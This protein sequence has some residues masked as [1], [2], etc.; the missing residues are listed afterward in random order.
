MK[1]KDF[2][3]ILNGILLVIMLFLSSTAS[4]QE[5]IITGTVTQNIG[6]TQEPIIGANIVLVNSQKRYLKG[7]VSDMDGNYSI[8]VPKNRLFSCSLS[9][10]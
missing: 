9:L 2:Q 8:S 5:N 7:A 6:G 3:L 10:R 4:A 1:Q